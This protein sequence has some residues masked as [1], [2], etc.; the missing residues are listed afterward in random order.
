[1]HEGIKDY[2]VLFASMAP[3]KSEAFGVI[4]HLDILI[5]ICALFCFVLVLCVNV[6]TINGMVRWHN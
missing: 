5:Y 3:L 6:N 1:M 2:I 4:L